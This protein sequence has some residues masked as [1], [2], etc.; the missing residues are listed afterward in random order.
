MEDASNRAAIATKG[1]ANNWIETLRWLDRALLGSGGLAGI[2][3]NE[4]SLGQ[5]RAA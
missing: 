5:L 1:H 2:P 3:A 4:A